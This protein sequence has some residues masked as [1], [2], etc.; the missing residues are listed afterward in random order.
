MA[1]ELRLGLPKESRPEDDGTAFFLDPVI[2]EETIRTVAKP[3]V[4]LLERRNQSAM[5]R[6][7]DGRPIT[8]DGQLDPGESVLSQLGE[9]HRYPM[10]SMVRER[11]RRWRFYHQIRTDPESPLRSVQIGTRTPV[12]AH[13][14]R[15]LA[16]AMQTI[17]EIGDHEQL[18][19]AVADAFDGARI[20]VAFGEDARFLLM[21]R[22]PG[23]RRSLEAAELSDGTLRY[24]ALLAALYSPRPPELLVLNEPETSLHPRVLEPLARQ[25]IAAA[26]RSQVIVVSHAAPL[27]DAV[28][29]ARDAVRIELVKPSGQTQVADRGQLDAPSWKWTT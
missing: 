2:K 7:D 8:F 16:A 17:V 20:E 28:C 13:D 22:T 9:P 5:L 25:I 14:G 1:Y 3:R 26:K 4:N 12:L 24:L 15:D 6:D 23:V 29:A 11:V 21:L 27:V 10:L 19:E 18:A